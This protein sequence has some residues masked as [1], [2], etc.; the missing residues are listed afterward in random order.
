M[1]SPGPQDL[2]RMAFDGVTVGVALADGSGKIIMANKAFATIAGAGHGADTDLR[3]LSDRFLPCGSLLKAVQQAVLDGCPTDLMLSDPE[4]ARPISIHVGPLP[5]TTA[6]DR[7]LL[8]EW[9][10]ADAEAAVERALRE[11]EERFRTLQQNLP[12]GIYRT[13]EDGTIQTA[14]PAL[15]SMMGYRSV[16]E[17]DGAALDDVWVAPPSRS[18]LIQ[19]LRKEGAVR[20]YIV[21][22]RRKDGGEFVGSLDARGTFDGNGRLLHFDAIVQDITERIHA[23]RELEHLA[24]TDGL[25]GLNNRQ[26]LM[27]GLESELARASRYGHL[28]TLM[29]LDLD[30]FKEVNDIH[31]HL[32]GDRVLATVATILRHTIRATDVAGRYGGEEFCVVLPETDVAG[33]CLMAERIRVALEAIRVE[34]PGGQVLRI[35]GSIGVAQA[36]STS[37]DALIARADAALYE[38]KRAGRNRV[39][40]SQPDPD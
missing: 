10:H 26:S 14:N 25:T 23:Q 36:C 28:L 4:S 20:G 5:K 33:A 17:L 6:G 29:I 22:L 13:G 37:T 15:L 19:R 31:G 35:T 40:V 39:V 11:S 3:V 7:L 2:Y 18:E 16:D 8:T 30:H 9:R 24:R 21:H 32:V 34:L 27:A 1:N 12:V 38:A